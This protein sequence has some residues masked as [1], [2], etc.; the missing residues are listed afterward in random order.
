MTSSSPTATGRWPRRWRWCS[1][2][3]SSFRSS[4]SSATNRSS[5][6]PGYE[7]PLFLVQRDLADTRL[8]VPLPANGDPRHLLLQR[9]EARHC[10]GGLL[11]EVVWRASA[12]PGLSRRGLDDAEGGGAVLH[13]CDDPRQDGC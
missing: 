3:C 4:S 8:R 12:E 13:P 6:R 11:D 1:S 10:L 2:S 9:I 7:P 5:G